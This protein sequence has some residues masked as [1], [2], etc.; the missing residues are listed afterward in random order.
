METKNN[1]IYY[2]KM[3][4]TR[5]RLNRSRS[6]RSRR[7]G[8]GRDCRTS[9][10]CNQAKFIEIENDTIIQGLDAGT[11]NKNPNY[12]DK[13]F[14]KLVN[15]YNAINQ[16]VRVG[17]ILYFKGGEQQY[18][19][20]VALQGRVYWL[21]DDGDTPDFMLNLLKYK[22]TLERHN[23]KYSKLFR[24]Q[25]YYVLKNNNKLKRIPDPNPIV[26]AYLLGRAVETTMP[27]EILNGLAEGGIQI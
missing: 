6:R 14:F 21:G 8:G 26:S 3:I 2:I 1:I 18:S 23:V 19:C 24:N 4:S 9:D 13:N 11:L 15:Q 27:Q 17:D 22:P 7:G 16:G 10:D 5:L 20:Y 25:A 12:K